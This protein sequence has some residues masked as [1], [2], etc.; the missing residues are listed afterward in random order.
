LAQGSR[1][2]NAGVLG[3]D[4]QDESMLLAERCLE[5]RPSVG[6]SLRPVVGCKIGHE[7]DLVDEEVGSQLKNLRTEVCD[8]WDLWT[9]PGQEEA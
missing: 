6:V 2:V 7:P 3:E 5:Q 1:R 9:D 4:R 8:G